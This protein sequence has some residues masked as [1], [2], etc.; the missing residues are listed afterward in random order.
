MPSLPFAGL[1]KRDPIAL[2]LAAASIGLGILFFTLLGSTSPASPGREI[3]ISEI[4]RLARDRDLRDARLLDHDARIVATTRSGVQLWAAYPASDVATESLRSNLEKQG[5]IVSVDQQTSKGR[6]QLIVQVFMP[7]VPL[8]CLFAFFTRLSQSGGGAGA[9]MSFS[10]FAGGGRRRNVP[11]SI[12][13]SQ[14]AGADEAVVELAE[15]R[16]Y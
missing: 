15:I 3:P 11:G 2:L 7:V 16:D 1:L 10:K 4:S 5:V 8:V 14:V 12:T 13:F 6:R 9:F